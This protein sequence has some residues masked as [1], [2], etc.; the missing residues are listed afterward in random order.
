M[1]LN[2]ARF[3]GRCTAA[4]SDGVTR[5]CQ[6]RLTSDRLVGQLWRRRVRRMRRRHQQQ[7]RRRRRRR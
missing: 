4:G 6:N 1:F 3:N 2:A 7:R 5:G